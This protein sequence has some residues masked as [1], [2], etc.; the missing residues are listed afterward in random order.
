LH[1]YHNQGVNIALAHWNSL[2][3]VAKELLVATAK[4]ISASVSG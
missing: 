2:V 4:G 3:T 1:D